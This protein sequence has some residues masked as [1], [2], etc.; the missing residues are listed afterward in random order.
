LIIEKGVIVKIHPLKTGTVKVKIS[1]RDGS[2]G[3]G[4]LRL[5]NT[6]LDRHWTP[7]MPIHAWLIE[8][9][10]GL[11]LIDTGETSKTSE[12]GYFPRWHPYYKFGVKLFVSPE[13]EVGPQLMRAGFQPEDVRWVIMTHLHTDHAG[14][15]EYFPKSEI[16]V[17]RNEL[18]AASGLGGILNGYLPQRWPDWFQPKLVDY[19]PDEGFFPQSHRLTKA[20][21][22][23]IVPTP[24]HTDGHQSIILYDGDRTVFFAGDATYSLKNLNKLVV[25]GV[26]LDTYQAASSISKIGQFVAAHNAVYLPS[27]DPV[28]ADRLEVS[29]RANFEIKSEEKELVK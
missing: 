20:E 18:K 23:V 22:V 4:Y 8:H 11:I 24:G 1:Q 17:S 10:E 27:H 3:A 21:D 13:D 7:K 25:D 16:L 5:A 19:M 28:S 26:S 12:S 2:Q 29:T 6:L 15:L 14:G 9:P